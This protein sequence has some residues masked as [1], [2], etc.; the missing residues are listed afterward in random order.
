MT[1][2]REWKTMRPE[3]IY[4]RGPKHEI[5]HRC[6]VH[7]MNEDSL[8]I[9]HTASRVSCGLRCSLAADLFRVHDF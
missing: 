9:G 5:A 1:S 8:L 2:A 3:I 7:I 4:E 6:R